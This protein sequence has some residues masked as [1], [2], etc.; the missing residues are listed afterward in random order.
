MVSLT[1]QIKA[2][3]HRLGFSSV[4]VAP[5]APPA[6]WASY[7]EWLAAG[8]AGDMAY[9]SRARE[10]RADPR[11]IVPGAKSILC[12]GMDYAAGSLSEADDSRARGRISRYALG[13]DYHEVMKARLLE[14]LRRIRSLEPSAE[15]RVY[16]DTGPVLERDFA[17]R[18]GLGWFGKHTNLIHRDRGSWFFLGEI[19]LTLDL[20]PDR[21]ASEHCGSCT[22]CI[23][24][25]P[26][27]ALREP[28]VLDARRCIS[29]LTIEFRESIP[30]EHRAQMGP[31][32]FG[33]DICQE[34]CP[35]NRK[36]EPA[37]VATDCEQPGTELWPD[38]EGLLLMDQAA[39]SRRFRGR[40]IKRTKR[41]GLLRNAAV[42]L[43]N[44]GDERHVPSLSRALE[45]PEPIVRGHAAWALGRIG[46]DRS[47][48]AL[49]GAL[50]REPDEAVCHEIRAASDQIASAGAT[51]G[52]GEPGAAMCNEGSSERCRD[53]PAAGG[54][55]PTKEDG[56]GRR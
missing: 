1:P 5:A 6:H 41:R 46:G 2:L 32:V 29:Y 10:R 42:A 44:V 25:C 26:T 48:R 56:F 8:H 51:A 52:R 34:V 20:E 54:G 19:I 49:A 22:R 50:A 36:R 21:P 47:R 40:A 3:A 35:W 13:E 11:A 33:C 37:E 55:P 30:I 9:L 53:R 31:W 15:G 27:G 43:G 39:F 23:D 7:V 16:V 24:A 28:Y 12:V 17:A 38:L 18:A 4:G 14:L 45:D